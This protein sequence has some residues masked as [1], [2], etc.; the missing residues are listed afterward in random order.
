MEQTERDQLL[1]RRKHLEDRIAE[2]EEIIDR[3]LKDKEAKLPDFRERLEKVRAIV[4]DAEKDL[5]E[6][7]R[8][9]SKL[10][11]LPEGWAVFRKPIGSLRPSTIYETEAEAEKALAKMGVGHEVRRARWVVE[12][13]WEPRGGYIEPDTTGEGYV[14]V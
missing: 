9:L 12:D 7:N 13:R 11:P 8:K 2:H 6:V 4:T 3:N 14:K 1:G 10:P 5:A